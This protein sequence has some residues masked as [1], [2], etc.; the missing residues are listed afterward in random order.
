MKNP[1][2]EQEKEIMDLL[3]EA[4]KKFMKMGQIHP[5]HIPEWIEGI[6][7]CQNVLKGRIVARDYPNVFYNALLP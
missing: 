7:K 3:I 4:H 6:H 2:T 5:S 1:F